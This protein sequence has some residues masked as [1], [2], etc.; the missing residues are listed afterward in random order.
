[1]L[2]SYLIILTLLMFFIDLTAQSFDIPSKHWGISF[3]NS[4]NFSGLRF[5]FRDRD[6]DRINGVNVT[7]WK[8]Y[9]NDYSEVHGISFGVIPE[10]D[11]PVW[12]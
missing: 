1:M 3:G 2:K 12:Y 8:S 10:A 7:F 9:E 5:N 4:K 11:L 6:V